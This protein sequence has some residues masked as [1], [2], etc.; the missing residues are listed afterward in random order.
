MLPAMLRGLLLLLQCPLLLLQLL[1]L[2]L[3]YHLPVPVSPGLLPA[4]YLQWLL[5]P[6]CQA[7]V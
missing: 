6:H 4:L 1:S 2:L 3:G 5:P 7:H